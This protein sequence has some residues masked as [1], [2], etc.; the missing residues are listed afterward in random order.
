MISIN[1][2]FGA[3]KHGAELFRDHDNGNEFYFHSMITFCLSDSFFGPV[4]KRTFLLAGGGSHLV[5]R[6]ICVYMKYD[7]AVGASMRT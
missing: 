6:G 1:E 4:H 5:V 7:A 2:D 3:K